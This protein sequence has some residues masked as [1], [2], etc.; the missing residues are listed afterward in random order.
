MHLKNNETNCVQWIE[1]FAKATVL[2]FKIYFFFIF[3]YYILLFFPT[4]CPPEQVSAGCPVSWLTP[5]SDVRRHSAFPPILP[6]KNS[7]N[8]SSKKLFR[9]KV[10]L[11]FKAPSSHLSHV[12]S[13]HVINDEILL[14]QL[15]FQQL[16]GVQKLLSL[17]EL[18]GH[19]LGSVP[20]LVWGGHILGGRHRG[21]Q[22]DILRFQ[23]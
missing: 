4:C 23:V 7:I 17:D 12:I 15:D 8:L 13:L 22:A 20:L 2:G 6:P 14:R 9:S 16:D 1:I 11:A 19:L 5:V 10:H 21:F 3:F 18:A